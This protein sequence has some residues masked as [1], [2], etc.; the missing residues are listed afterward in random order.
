MSAYTFSTNDDHT[1]QE[2]VP[3]AE[4]SRIFETHFPA[5]NIPLGL[6]L[7]NI[8]HGADYRVRSYIDGIEP[9]D[10]KYEAFKATV[11]LDTWHETALLGA[12]CTWL[13]VSKWDRQFQFGRLTATN[14]LTSGNDKVV[15]IK[16]E[17]PYDQ[18]PKIVVWFHTVNID[19]KQDS[20]IHAHA[21]DVTTS[22]F[23][24]RVHT[25]GE[26][27]VYDSKISWV[28]VPLNY[29]NITAGSFGVSCLPTEPLPGYKEEIK[30]DKS[31]PRPPRVL[32]A[33]NKFHTSNKHDLRIEAKA[34]NVTP[35]GMTLTIKTW[36]DSVLYEAGA[37]YIVIVD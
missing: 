23:R 34:E 27:V 18:V 36:G 30:F 3:R 15:D 9:V 22:G 31:F 32:I 12:G 1:R 35:E 16:F 8:K 14:R 26:T 11:H 4:N 7:I 6:N 5:E 20:R 13:D 24:L 37:D 33:L 28:A 17:R 2:S 29:P 19:R 25:W 10:K 21:E